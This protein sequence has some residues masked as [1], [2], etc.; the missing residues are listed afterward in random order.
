MSKFK[1][2]ITL[3][4]QIQL[5]ITNQKPIKLLNSFYIIYPIDLNADI[6]KQTLI[7]LNT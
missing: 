6:L 4:W 1:K 5:D 3:D 7:L 2:R